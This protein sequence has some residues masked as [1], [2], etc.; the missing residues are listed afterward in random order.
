MLQSNQC[1]LL[2][3][4]ESN[5]MQS[6]NPVKVQS[7]HMQPVKAELKKSQVNTMSQVQTSKYKSDTRPKL[8]L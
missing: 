7:T 3:M 1:V 2:L 4:A 5:C 8:Y 6:V